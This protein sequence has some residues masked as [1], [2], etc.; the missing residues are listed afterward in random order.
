MK[1]IISMLFLGVLINT[2]LF[3]EPPN[4]NIPAVVVDYVMSHYPD[5][6]DIHWKRTKTNMYE[7]DF[8]INGKEVLIDIYS[9]GEWIETE[10]E[11]S[12]SDLPNVIKA[13]LNQ[14]TIIF[15]AEVH[16]F[17]GEKLYVA[18]IKWNRKIFDVT[19][20]RQGNEIERHQ[21]N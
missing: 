13:K 16:N 5:A 12:P 6:K 14:S 11:I 19:F 7:A 17:H 9:T 18:E 1:K 3:A 15:A 8:M 10:T 20:D 4:K 21:I 2:V